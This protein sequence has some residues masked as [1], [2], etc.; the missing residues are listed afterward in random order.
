MTEASESAVGGWV[1]IL[2]CADDS[3]YVGS[4][5]HEAVE[6]REAEHNSGVFGGYTLSR[7]PV[8]LVWAEHFEDLRDAHAAERRLKGWSRAKKEALITGRW[9]LVRYLAKRPTARHGSRLASRAPHHDGD[10]NKKDQ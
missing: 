1:Y 2:R 10:E 4:T 7:R 5:S 8:K 6:L 3:L 9:D